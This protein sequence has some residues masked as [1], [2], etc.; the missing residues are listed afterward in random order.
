[1][2]KLKASIYIVLALQAAVAHAAVGLTEIQGLES[3]GPVTVFFPSNDEAKPVL[4]GGVPLDVAFNGVPA[5]GNG[6][7]IVISHGSPASPWVYA[8]LARVLVGA[9]YVVAMPEHFADNYKDDSDPGISS[10]KRRPLE[11]SRAIDAVGRDARF[12]SLLKLDK[13]GMYGMS[14]G[15]HTALTLAGGRWS[16]AQLLRHCETH[17]AEDFNTCAGP[18]FR[19][20]GGLFDSLKIGVSLGIIRGKYA[21]DAWYSYTDPRISAI[22]SGVPFAADFDM[23]SLT[24]NHVPLGIVTARADKWLTPK[25]HSDK[26][27]L[28]CTKCIRVADIQSG[29]HGALLSPLPPNRTGAIA[30]LIA[31]APGFDRA[32][33]VPELNGKITLFFQQYL[34]TP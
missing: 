9:G 10:W 23:E 22:V 16:P 32:R 33:V 18:N 7:L 31:D 21:D 1:M 8:D 15:G 2:F 6:R 34:T 25:F 26:V 4:R 19:L 27:L 24:T 14:A 13:V 28:A 5:R 20:T 29:G 12:G 17:I 11:V 3:D 30:D